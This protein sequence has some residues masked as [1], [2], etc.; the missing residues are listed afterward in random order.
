MALPLF[1][2]VMRAQKCGAQSVT[3]RLSDGRACLPSEECVCSTEAV[4]LATRERERRSCNEESVA[5]SEHARAVEL[6]LCPPQLHPGH[7]ACLEL[8]RAS[9]MDVDDDAIAIEDP[10]FGLPAADGPSLFA[11]E[12]PAGDDVESQSDA[13]DDDGDENAE[14]AADAAP[15][16]AAPAA[17]EAGATDEAHLPPWMRTAHASIIH[18][19]T[20]SASSLGLDAGLLKSLKRMGV[21]KAFPVQAA[22]VPIVLAAHAAR[23]AG[24]VC[25]SA[26][27]G[28]GKTLAYALPVVQSLLARQVVRLRAL[29]FT[30]SNVSCPRSLGGGL[31]VPGFWIESALNTSDNPSRG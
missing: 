14:A 19:S 4:C 5:A 8:A 27:T 12:I 15:A 17:K 24:D 22:V 16:S 11:E 6:V 3:H 25:V 1:A 18:P 7:V 23:C 20:P 28:S 13:D 2:R 31:Q 21:R 9:A 29:S 30:N 10:F 26:P